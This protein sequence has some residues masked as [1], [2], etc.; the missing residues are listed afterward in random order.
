[1]FNSQ[2]KKVK[3]KFYL[4]PVQT[5][6]Q[7]LLG[8]LFV[9]KS[10]NKIISGMIVETEA[11]DSQH[12]AASHSYKGI[13]GR[14]KIMFESGG[15]L[16][17]YLIY[18]IHYCAN[19]VTGKNGTGAAVL[20]RAVEPIDGA[21]LMSKNRFGKK[22]FSEKEKFSLTSGPAKL[23]E[24]FALNSIHN[25]VKLTEENIFICDFKKFR[26]EEI[27]CSQRIG[28]SKSKELMWRYFV[29]DNPFVSKP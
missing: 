3:E 19:V 7:N 23:C 25:G 15:H 24:A 20:L 27:T 29:K 26:E 18:G 1:M 9:K 11:Y 10:G 14:N 17:I 22:S 12:D 2:S 21:E 16:Y 4:S 28:I 6:A 5:V 8:K 13:N